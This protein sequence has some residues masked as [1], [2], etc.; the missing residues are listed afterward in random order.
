MTASQACLRNVQGESRARHSE[1]CQSLPS[2]WG[3][4]AKGAPAGAAVW[5][6]QSMLD[7]S[8]KFSSVSP[9]YYFKTLLGL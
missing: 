1:Y 8:R 6:R 9:Q 3:C 4:V 7:C 5:E 2:V